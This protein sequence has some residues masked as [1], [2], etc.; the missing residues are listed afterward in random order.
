MNKKGLTILELLAV[1]VLMALVA[2]LIGL[3]I[4]NYQ[5]NQAVISEESKA[6]IEADL[7]IRKLNNDLDE[8]K[9]DQYD[10]CPQSNCLVLINAFDY[11]YDGSEIILNVY[12]PQVESTLVFENQS[13]SLGQ[14]T[15]EV[16]TFTWGE[17][18]SIS[19][20]EENN[21]LIITIDFILVGNLDTYAYSM[22]YDF[23]IQDLP[24]A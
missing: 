3:L 24:G 18:T 14:E 1:L 20:V 8:F 22:T 12:D 13:L 21:Y 9:A 4:S 10:V 23:L 7:F 6:S 2:T 17:N 16:E 5:N 19:Y 15:Y 11:N